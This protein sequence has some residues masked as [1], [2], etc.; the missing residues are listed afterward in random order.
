MA[1]F[2]TSLALLQHQARL[3]AAIELKAK[4]M[5]KEF[6]LKTM[7]REYVVRLSGT[8]TTREL[9]NAGHPF[10]R[11]RVSKRGYARYRNPNVKGRRLTEKVSGRN[12]GAAAS[13]PLLPINAQSRRLMRSLRARAATAPPSGQSYEL[14]FTTPYAEFILAKDGTS[15]MVARGYQQEIKKVREKRNKDLQRELKLMILKASATG[16]V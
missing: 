9:T 3:M 13:F 15:K 10:A 14:G 4:A 2:S 6:V 7:V 12:V 5:H 11:K 8:T 1:R 16:R